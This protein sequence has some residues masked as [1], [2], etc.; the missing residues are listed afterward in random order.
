M[1]YIFRV[2]I[3]IIIIT[4][5]VIIIIAIVFTFYYFIP[6]SKLVS[7]YVLSYVLSLLSAL[8]AG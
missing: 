6:P 7:E 4:T 1:A 2:I 5:T 3:I 8:G